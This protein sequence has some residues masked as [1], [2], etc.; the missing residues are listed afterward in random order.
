MV[1]GL[2]E[3]ILVFYPQMIMRCLR[4]WINKDNMLLHL[5]LLLHVISF[6]MFNANKLEEG[7]SQLVDPSVGVW[8][9]LLLCE[10]W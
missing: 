8:V 9:V 7:A 4:T 2:Q 1:L 6:D 10:Q 5:Q 3:I